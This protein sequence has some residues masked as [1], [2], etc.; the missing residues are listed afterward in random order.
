MSG[1]GW[2]N[3]KSGELVEVRWN[4][5]TTKLAKFVRHTG[6]NRV[7]LNVERVDAKGV[8]RGVY[9]SDRMFDRDDIVRVVASSRPARPLR[10]TP[11]SSRRPPRNTPAPADK[12]SINQL[13]REK[14]NMAV[15]SIRLDAARIA[16]LDHV[17]KENYVG[18]RPR[19]R[20]EVIRDA[21]DYYLEA[22]RVAATK[23]AAKTR[24]AA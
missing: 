8:P 7:V 3:V 2:V 11:A 10:N 15:L 24:R 1:R 17:A 20:A 9:G 23:S 14:N 22:M 19:T 6:Y 18:W 5:T 13:E 12:K 21:I 16:K 4:P